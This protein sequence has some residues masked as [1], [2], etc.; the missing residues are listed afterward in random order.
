MAAYSAVIS[1]LQTL[2]QRTPE[3]MIRDQTLESIHATA[4]YFHDVLEN[5]RRFDHEKIKTLEEKIRVAASGA[6][7][8]V[9]LKISQGSNWTFENLIQVA[10]KMNTTKQQVMDIV[11][12]DVHQILELSVDSLISTPSTSYPILSDSDQLGLEDDLKIIIKRLTGP[13]SD[14]D[15][16]TITGMGGIG[17][18]TLAKK[19]YDHLTIRYHFDVFAWLTISQEFRCRN[20]LLEALHCILG[21]P[22][23]FDSYPYDENEL[24]DLVQKQLK[25]RRYLVVVDDIW[26]SDVWDS[27]RGIFPNYNNGSRILLTTRENEVAMYAN[28]C[29]PHEMS[30]LSAENGWKLLCDKVFGPNNDHPP[31]LE[32]IGKEIV[33]KCQGLPLTISVIAGHLSKVVRTLESWKDVARTLSKIIASHPDKCLAVL[34]LS[35]HHLPSRLKPC[36]LSMSSFPEDFR[37]ETQIL[38]QLWIA[39]GFIRTCENGK[40]LEEVAIYYLEDLISRNLLQAR[41]RRFNGEIKTCGI[42][43]LLRE[44]CL[45]EAEMTKHMHVERTHPTLPTQKHNVRR[46]SFQTEYYS[47]DDCY[48]LLPPVSRSIYLFSKLNLPIVPSTE[49]HLSSPIYR[50]DPIIHELFSHFNLLRVLSMNN[51]GVPFESFPLVITELFHLRYLQVHFE[52]D[53]PESISELQNLQTLISSGTFP[54]DMTLP[55]KIWMMKN[56]RY[57]R[58]DRP[59]YL[60]SPGTQSLVTGMPNLQEFS[61]HFTDEVFSGIP[62]LKRLI[63]HLPNNKRSYRCWQLDISRLTKLESFK[64]YGTFLTAYRV[65]RFYFPAS[66]RR[67]SLTQCNEFF[68]TNISSTVVMLPNLEELKLKQ[69]GDM[70]KTWRLS[71]EDKF[72]SLKLLLLSGSSLKHWE[73]TS[74]N[75]PNLKRLVLKNCYR[76]Q[77]IPADFGEIGTLES[78]ELHNCSTTADDSAREI[79]Q[80]QEEMG[81]YFLK[82]YIHKSRRK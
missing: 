72:K 33:E 51:K 37:F 63:F 39:E 13:P 80:E 65:K 64:Y 31:E 54:F 18:T 34:G 8:V 82:V 59:T 77:E 17:K 15:I 44:F 32:E 22:D 46:F 56:L 36:F 1:L 21:K 14:I 3:L 76:L 70:L 67:L 25:G 52:G 49:S 2:E 62:N 53:I 58:L 57:I 71:D 11:S 41:K 6:E 38:I 29:S 9:E 81:N 55:M 61:G 23:S 16:V 24:A 20:V 42:H 27:I 30:L 69:C 79:V 66:L 75:F 7:D 60:P 78:I 47:V 19:A 28:S 73:A 45:T 12:H 5:I 35:Y 48:K 50:H 40:S 74:D 10:E 43:D 4:H 26:S 68:E